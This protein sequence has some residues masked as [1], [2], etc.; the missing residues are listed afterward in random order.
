M[1][2]IFRVLNRAKKLSVSLSACQPLESSDDKP[3]KAMCCKTSNCDN[4]RA[5][6]EYIQAF[7]MPFR[8]AG[9]QTAVWA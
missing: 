6:G 9:I 2:D 3:A 8:A 1:F 5:E 4:T 7:C